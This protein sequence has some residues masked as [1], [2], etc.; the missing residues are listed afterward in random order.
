MIQSLRAWLKNHKKWVEQAAA[1]SV[2]IVATFLAVEGVNTFGP[3]Q[4][5]ERLISDWEIAAISPPEPQDPDVVVVAITEKT[6]A[7]FHYRSPIDRGF[8]AKLVTSL[9]AKKPRAV[10]IDLL[11]D[12]PT[13]PAK[14][15]AL[16]KVLHN[17][18]V[19]IVAAYSDDPRIVTARQLATLR[20]FVPEKMR[21]YATL[22][23]DS[24]GVVRWIYP[25]K[26]G[27]DGH[28]IPSLA[29]GLAAKAGIPLSHASTP[30]VWRGQPA[31]GDKA[32]REFQAQVASF[33][34]ASWFAG[35]IVL[36][37]SDLSLTDR[38]RTPFD[39]L[40]PVQMAGVTIQAYAVSQ[41]IHHRAP[42]AV[43]WVMNLLIIFLCAAM[44]A[45]LG[46]MNI[47]LVARVGFG[48]GFVVLLWITGAALFHF[49]GH[50]IQLVT[51]SLAMTLSLWA[52]ESLT[53]REARK[54]REFIQGAFSHYVS[55]KVVEQL[56]HDPEKMSLE[57]ERR[58]MTFLFS[59][60][61]NFT[62][63]SEGLDSRELA[64]VLNAYLDGA[65]EEVLRFEGMVD[66][67][68]GD[69]VFAIFNAPV[70]M[71]DHAEAAVKCALAMDRFASRFA[72]EQQARGIPFGITRIGVHTGAAVIGNFGS[73]SRFNYTAQGDAVN[74]ASRLEGL[75]KHFGT[76]LC[77]SDATKHECR[78]ITFRPIAEVVL[79]GKTEPV[80]VW[81]PL[82]EED[83]HSGFLA[84]YEAAYTA[85]KTG[86]ADAGTL[87]ATLAAEAPEDPLVR[88][89]RERLQAGQ[90]GTVIVMDEK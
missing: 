36:I 4:N 25:G 72:R 63:M 23:E 52:T 8:I 13:E 62:T 65:T 69:A 49:G 15:N 32:I 6:L 54:Q 64:R 35:K 26:M 67:F 20:R 87:L 70:D 89:H 19:P 3:L 22:G 78:S 71:P 51:P 2:A 47:P 57:G 12:Q 48:A 7:R 88:L 21:G 40:N 41:L 5:A 38:H 73:H 34:P 28:W 30:M 39:V 58:E 80:G 53:G 10:G 1:F 55:P 24:T 16:V 61:A 60:I 11:F 86:A 14:D 31:N 42:L 44:G 43:G 9:E 33:L 27:R 18:T 84:R 68:I 74:T 29:R 59:D 46:A 45:Q 75:N 79:K 50:Q 17:A 83:V 82:H 90:A 81:E 66:K 76:R 37:G 85:L 77:V 56:V